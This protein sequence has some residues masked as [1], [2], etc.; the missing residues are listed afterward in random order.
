MRFARACGLPVKGE[1]ED[2]KHDAGGGD[3]RDGEGGVR[4]PEAERALFRLQH[5]E[6]AERSRQI[7]HDREGF[8]AVGGNEFKDVAAAGKRG[9]RAARAD[10]IDKAL[11]GKGS[12]GR[13]RDQ[14]P[15]GVADIKEA[16]GLDRSRRQCVNERRADALG[17][18]F[19]AEPARKRFARG[20]GDQREFLLRVEECLTP[21]VENLYRRTGCDGGEKHDD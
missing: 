12:C 17:C 1:A 20:N 16:P 7:A 13:V 18:G 4:I 10:Q 2:Q 6:L 14:A 5:G 8:P 19:F 9:Q 15:A 3:E 21:S 11:A